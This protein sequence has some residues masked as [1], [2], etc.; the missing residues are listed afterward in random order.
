MGMVKETTLA[1][2]NRLAPPRFIAFVVISAVASVVASHL[3]GWSQAALIGFDIGATIFLL[4]CISLLG[5]E[6]DEMRQAAKR[7]DAN[8][9]VLLGITT[10]VC[11]VV[12]VAIGVELSNKDQ[13]GA[14]A[15][16]LIV[17]TL[18]IAWLFS[19]LVYALHYAHLF[20]SP[21]GGGGDAG[22]IDFPGDG[23]PDYWDFIY[24]AFTLGMTFQTSDVGISARP[25]RR[26]VIVHCFAAFIFNIGVLAFT[27]NVLGG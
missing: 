26:V 21:K 23:D 15:I 13:M 10:V 1:L 4:S 24:F 20:Y 17:G 12:L 3:A 22:G 9:A 27:I 18:L 19:N 16:V 6:A 2:G 5:N 14:P 25:I 11:L 7:N 8:R